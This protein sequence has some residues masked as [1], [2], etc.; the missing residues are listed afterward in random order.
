MESGISNL[1][2]LEDLGIYG[3]KAEHDDK[4]FTDY[5]QLLDLQKLK[6]LTLMDVDLN[7]SHANIISRLTNLAHLELFE[8]DREGVLSVYSN[9]TKLSGLWFSLELNKLDPGLEFRQMP[10]LEMVTIPMCQNVTQL[11]HLSKLRE[12]CLLSGGN[13]TD[14]SFLKDL[15][16][17]LQKLTLVA[18]VL[19]TDAFVDLSPMTNLNYIELFFNSPISSSKL[20]IYEGTHDNKSQ[21]KKPVLLSLLI[22]RNNSRALLFIIL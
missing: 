11:A 18:E 21:R 7:E 22:L 12:L 1:T 9:L 3:C 2:N 6:R 10:Y 13:T 8:L 14:L 4:W 20:N 17:T 19:P 5:N 16:T 15:S